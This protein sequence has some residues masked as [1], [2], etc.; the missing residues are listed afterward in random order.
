MARIAR[1]DSIDLKDIGQ[2][3]GPYGIGALLS[4]FFREIEVV[5]H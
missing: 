4:E 5:S 3:I 1:P 2:E